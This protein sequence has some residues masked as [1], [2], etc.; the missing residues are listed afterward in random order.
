MHGE[1]APETL[2]RVAA[3]LI[4][5]LVLSPVVRTVTSELNH[6]LGHAWPFSLSHCHVSA[7]PG[8]NEDDAA[9]AAVSPSRLSR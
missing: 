4:L 2:F 9:R 5:A 6:S 1:G 3:A 7:T 8:C